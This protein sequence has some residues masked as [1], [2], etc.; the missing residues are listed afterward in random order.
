MIA[1]NAYYN[2]KLAGVYEQMYPIDF[3]TDAAVGFLG[4]L[5]PAPASVL[6]LGIGTGRIAVP[7]AAR[8]Y[9]VHGIDGSQAMLDKLRERDPEGAVTAELGDFTATSTGRTYDLVTLV[10][11]TFFVAVTKEQQIG[12]LRNVREQLAPGGRFVLDAFD[13]SPYHA[14]QK[15]E[16][17]VRYLN[18]GAVMLDSITV[19]RS[20]QLMMATHTIVDGGPPETTHHVIRYAFPLEIDLLAELAGLRLVARYDGWGKG[21]FTSASARH[22][23][24]YERA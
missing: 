11:N 5:V 3:D 13:P 9:Q 22:I 4:G 20:R 12:C 6:E 10:L 19:D 8:G 2:E 24:V 14:Q 23:S 1:A 21:P 7:L 17:S 15:P 18:E 16:A